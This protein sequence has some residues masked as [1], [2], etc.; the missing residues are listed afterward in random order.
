MG[1]KCQVQASML[2]LVKEPELGY[3]LYLKKI[4]KAGL[5]TPKFF[6]T[7]QE[8][9]WRHVKDQRITKKTR[10]ELADHEEDTQ[11]STVGWINDEMNIGFQT[12]LFLL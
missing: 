5:S 11:R 7:L 12:I 8:S 2:S 3:N 6:T 10:G 9:I 1:V 4:Q